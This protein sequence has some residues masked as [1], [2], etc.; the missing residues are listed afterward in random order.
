M[1][2]KSHTIVT[3]DVTREQMWRL[4]ANVNEWHTWDKEI[5]FA[6]LEGK[7]ERGNYF[8]LRPNGG[9]NVKVK[10]LETV[11]DKSFLDVTEFPFAKMYDQH[12]FEDSDEG[13]KITNTITVK[14]LLTFLWVK[15]VAQ[16]IADAMPDD[17]Q[18]QIK[19]ASKL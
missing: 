6:K 18:E 3:K 4:F 1:W 8:L 10:L 19:A 9:P 14:G 15:I 11:K 17:M 5:E 2:T 12:L 16:K 13:L 7:F